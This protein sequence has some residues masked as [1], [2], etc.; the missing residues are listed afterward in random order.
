MLPKTIFCFVVLSLTKRF[1]KGSLDAM[2]SLF[3]KL[4]ES[5]GINILFVVLL[6]NG[7]EWCELWNMGSNTTTKGM[8]RFESK[9]IG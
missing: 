2:I 7:G 1:L 8:T 4:C 3:L 5:L 9:H 6:L